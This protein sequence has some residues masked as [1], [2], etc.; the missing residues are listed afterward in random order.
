MSLCFILIHLNLSNYYKSNQSQHLF[1]IAIHRACVVTNPKWHCQLFTT[2]VMILCSASHPFCPSP[3]E[4]TSD[5]EEN[6][7]LHYLPTDLY[8]AIGR[9]FECERGNRNCQ[10]QVT[11][12]G[13]EVH[14]TCARSELISGSSDSDSE[15]KSTPSVLKRAFSKA[16]ILATRPGGSNSRPRPPPLPRP[17]VK[18]L[19]REQIRL[20]SQGAGSER[21]VRAPWYR[22]D[23]RPGLRR[24]K[25][26]AHSNSKLTNYK[27]QSPSE[28]D[29]G[30][31]SEA[32]APP[33]CPLPA[34]SKARARQ[35]TGVFIA[36]RMGSR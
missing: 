2:L 1:T 7:C 13:I 17:L 32:A 5:D 28:S 9:E 3:P 25:G 21:V 20:A 31:E 29:S 23:D 14:R 12:V 24:A 8:E 19:V 16:F 15:S 36:A 35:R 6:I 4:W 34:V 10:A 22:K 27:V 18:D 33:T 26:E 30:S 11:E